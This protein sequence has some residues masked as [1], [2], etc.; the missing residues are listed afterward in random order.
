MELNTESVKA[1]T[2]I[3][4]DPKAQGLPMRPL[5]ECFEDADV[6]TPKHLLF[7]DYKKEVG[8]NLPKVFFYIIMDQEYP[9]K[10][11]KAPSGELGYLLRFK[12][13]KATG[14]RSSRSG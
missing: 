14:S 5:A 11:A 13:D 1:Y 8:N 4:K 6:A 2:T 10:I 3:L 9:T 7:E 12:E